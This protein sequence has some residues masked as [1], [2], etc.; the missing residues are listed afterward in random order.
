MGLEEILFENKD[1]FKGEFVRIKREEVEDILK[2][3]EEAIPEKTTILYT[4]GFYKQLRNEKN[5]KEFYKSIEDE[6][7]K[8]KKEE[9]KKKLPLSM[10]TITK[11]LS[12]RIYK[13]TKES[14]G[15]KERFNGVLSQSKDVVEQFKKG[16]EKTK[17]L[18]KLPKPLKRVFN[19]I[20][21]AIRKKIE[22]GVVQR[23]KDFIEGNSHSSIK[24]Y[25]KTLRGD[26]SVPEKY[27]EEWGKE[28]YT[29]EL[30]KIKEI[31]KSYLKEEYGEERISVEKVPLSKLFLE[32]NFFN[33]L[34]KEYPGKKKGWFKGNKKL[35][36]NDYIAFPL[37]LGFYPKERTED[38]ESLINDFQNHKEI[39]DKYRS[40]LLNL[41]IAEVVNKIINYENS[42]LEIKK[43]EEERDEEWEEGEERKLLYQTKKGLVKNREEFMRTSIE[44]EGYVPF[45][46]K[47][48]EGLRISRIQ[49]DLEDEKIAKKEG[50]GNA[51]T[52]QEKKDIFDMIINKKRSEFKPEEES[53]KTYTA[54]K[55][56]YPIESIKKEIL[57]KDIFL[58]FVFNKDYSPNKK[59]RGSRESEPRGEEDDEELNGEENYYENNKTKRLMEEIFE[60]DSVEEEDEEESGND[61]KNTIDEEHIDDV[62]KKSKGEEA[63]KTRYAGS[64]ASVEEIDALER[65]EYKKGKNLLNKKEE[66]GGLEDKKAQ[67]SVNL[68]SIDIGINIKKNTLGVYKVIIKSTDSSIEKELL[69][70]PED[71]T[72]YGKTSIY[73]MGKDT[74]FGIEVEYDDEAE[75]GEIIKLS[76]DDYEKKEED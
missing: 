36:E 29:D 4:E 6:I 9:I 7:K 20:S 66:T 75:E 70:D 25:L 74:Y 76:V 32:K 46:N 50:T 40:Q 57:N 47:E 60:E 51:I 38:C 19:P 1:Y 24:K 3:I 14:V 48:E 59:T 16:R 28:E 30:N 12:E 65:P 5:R 17:I 71:T 33:F 41:E 67:Y 52:Y 23:L 55:E 22:T 15:T 31:K 42:F 44:R 10:F 61:S 35:A 21:I 18:E 11:A 62:V 63:E 54:T 37:L 56:N 73:K 49:V 2:R 39:L 45:W 68:G 27:K 43:I 72:T 58:K 34:E 64:K 13:E 69:I 26:I 8:S 53:S